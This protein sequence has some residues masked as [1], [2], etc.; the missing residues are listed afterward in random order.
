MS[1]SIRRGVPPNTRTVM[2][3][4]TRDTVKRA[5]ALIAKGDLE[6]RIFNSRG[7]PVE[8]QAL[9]LVVESLP[10]QSA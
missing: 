5:Q 6:F 4:T 7:E 2:R 10:D 9:E 3:L 8:L 1:Y